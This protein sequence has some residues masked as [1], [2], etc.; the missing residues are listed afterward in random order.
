MTI[1]EYGKTSASGSVDASLTDGT[2]ATHVS[3]SWRCHFPAAAA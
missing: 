2:Q 1:T 3:G